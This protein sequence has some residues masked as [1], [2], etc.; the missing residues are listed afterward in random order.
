MEPENDGLPTIAVSGTAGWAS[1]QQVVD[2]T[3]NEFFTFQDSTGEPGG[4]IF[5]SAPVIEPGIEFLE[6][7]QPAQPL[8]APLPTEP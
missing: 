7:L 1:G 4:A 2:I 6:P 3:P 5:I 8:Q